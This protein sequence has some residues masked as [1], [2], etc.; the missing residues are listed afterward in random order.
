[1]YAPAHVEAWRRITRMVHAWSPARICLQLGHSGPKGATKRMWEG[2]E[3]PLDDGGWP[4]LAPTASRTTTG[5]TGR[6]R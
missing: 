5:C 3:E 6:G 1:M 2:N 4:I